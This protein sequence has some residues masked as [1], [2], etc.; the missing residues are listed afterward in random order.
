M[1]NQSMFLPSTVA[2]RGFTA[3][4]AKQRQLRLKWQRA[5]QQR[6]E[7]LRIT[8]ELVGCTDRQLAELGVC[9]SEIPAIAHGTYRH[10]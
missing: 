4:R 1:N 10:A 5:R 8:Q 3:L 6:V 7:V 9:R 2:F